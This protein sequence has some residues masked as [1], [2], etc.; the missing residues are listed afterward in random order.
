MKVR[1]IIILLLIQGLCES[2]MGV[3]KDCQ[4]AAAVFLAVPYDEL[5]SHQSEIGRPQMLTEALP[6]GT[7]RADSRLTPPA[8]DAS[9]SGDASAV[10]QQQQQSPGP[11]LLPDK[12][13][14]ASSGSTT[15]GNSSATVIGGFVIPAAD[16]FNTRADYSA[17]AALAPARG[18]ALALLLIALCLL[19]L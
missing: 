17:A 14:S 16:D 10:S 3:C 9:L 11:E 13:G 4:Q 19:T 15:R 2:A 6:A 8:S 18:L 1:I 12:T 7:A 5:A